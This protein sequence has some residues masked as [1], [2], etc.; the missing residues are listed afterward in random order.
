M[1]F[2]NGPILNNALIYSN[3]KFHFNYTGGEKR[4]CAFLSLFFP[5]LFVY[6]HLAIL[7]LCYDHK[8]QPPVSGARGLDVTLPALSL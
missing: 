1:I 4:L 3:P 2:D 8:D 5:R 6:Y 7:P